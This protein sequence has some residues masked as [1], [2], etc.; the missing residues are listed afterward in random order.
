MNRR[1]EAAQRSYN[2]R[3]QKDTREAHAIAGRLR[4][5]ATK[6]EEAC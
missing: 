3:L 5:L 4:E 1:A 6:L 2:K